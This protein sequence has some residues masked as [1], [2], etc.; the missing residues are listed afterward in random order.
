MSA[1]S[2]SSGLK[3]LKNAASPSST[4]S[5]PPPK[6][7][8]TFPLIST[9]FPHLDLVEITAPW[10]VR[11]TSGQWP[12]TTT[13]FIPDEQL[14]V[15]PG[16]KTPPKPRTLNPHTGLE[17]VKETAGRLEWTAGE[18]PG[19]NELFYLASF[20]QPP[21]DIYYGFVLEGLWRKEHYDDWHG[22]DGGGGSSYNLV[23]YDAETFP[24]EFVSDPWFNSEGIGRFGRH[25]KEGDVVPLAE[26]ED[27]MHDKEV[28]VGPYGDPEA[29]EQPKEIGIFW[30]SKNGSGDRYE[31]LELF[32][33]C[34]DENDRHEGYDE[35]TNVAFSEI[36]FLGVK[37]KFGQDGY[38][39]FVLGKIYDDDSEEEEDD[40]DGDDG[41]D[42]DDDCVNSLL[43]LRKSN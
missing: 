40:D 39:G 35:V 37:V 26:S 30:T 15:A 14:T 29:I 41:D 11:D 5:R 16:K 18:G 9:A 20:P 7:M 19:G 38:D 22:G 12:R 27:A 32:F 36:L 10:V 3:A 23:V 2:A 4:G 21:L 25:G 13:H 31:R 28:Y 24:E 17:N 1:I 8:A 34:Y 42:D 6:D 43:H 33:R